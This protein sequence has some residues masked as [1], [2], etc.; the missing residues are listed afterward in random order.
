QT[1]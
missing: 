1:S